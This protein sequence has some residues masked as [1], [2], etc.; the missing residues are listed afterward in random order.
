MGT[1]NIDFDA[2]VIG[3]GIAGQEAAL[4]LADMNHKV[5]LV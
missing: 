5:L 4:S 2:L 3:G 1:K